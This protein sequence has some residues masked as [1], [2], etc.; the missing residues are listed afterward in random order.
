MVTAIQHMID[1]SPPHTTPPTCLTHPSPTEPHESH[2]E[3]LKLPIAPPS[4][5]SYNPPRESSPHDRT[6]YETED[7]D[8]PDTE[9]VTQ[10]R[11]AHIEAL[12]AELRAC[13]DEAQRFRVCIDER[14]RLTAILEAHNVEIAM[15]HKLMAEECLSYR[16]LCDTEQLDARYRGTWDHF[17]GVA[18][19]GG[20]ER[21]QHYG[22]YAESRTFCKQ[23]AAAAKEVP[24]WEEAVV[25]LNQIRLS[26]HRD[27]RKSPIK[28]GKAK[29]TTDDVS[30]LKEWRGRSSNFDPAKP[31][32]QTLDYRPVWHDEM[33]EHGLDIH[34]LVVEQGDGDVSP[35]PARPDVPHTRDAPEHSATTTGPSAAKR[36]L[37]YQIEDDTQD[38]RR[39]KQV[40]DQ[41]ADVSA[42]ERVTRQS[43][44]TV[45]SRS[46]PSSSDSDPS[47][48]VLRGHQEDGHAPP[49]R[50]NHPTPAPPERI[51]SPPVSDSQQPADAPVDC[52]IQRNSFLGQVHQHLDSICSSPRRPPSTWRDMTSSQMH[53]LLTHIRKPNT[54]TE[55]GPVEAYFVPSKE[56]RKLLDTGSVTVPIVVLDDQPF[57]WCGSSQPIEQLFSDGW[58]VD[59]DRKVSVQIPSLGIKKQSYQ[60]KSLRHI[61]DRFI[62]NEPT[63]D[64]WNLLNFANPLPPS[65][66]PRFLT[67]PNCQLI[68]RVREH[69]LSRNSAERETASAEDVGKWQAVTDW[70]L[71]SQGGHNTGPH[72]DSHGMGTWITVQGGGLGFGY[73]LPDR[74]FD[75]D[76]WRNDRSYHAGRNRYIILE[77]QQTVYFPPGTIHFVFRSPNVQTLA[78]GGHVLQWSGI[79]RWLHVIK[80]QELDPSTTNEHVDIDSSKFW[81]TPILELVRKRVQEGAVQLLGGA[82]VADDIMKIMNDWENWKPDVANFLGDRA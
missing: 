22:W 46:P 52:T 5:S 62:P 58:I 38:Q 13:T 26:R 71:M 54:D 27:I 41:R 14:D 3:T 42:P 73:I 39:K 2:L 7:I 82:D 45:P 35:L 29:I 9:L 75:W 64:P 50:S 61:R 57:E 6:P 76:A 33:P 24:E 16:H 53:H 8:L 43:P 67:G 11:A 20:T 81:R 19:K 51:N 68:Q 44:R 70:A 15:S 40:S 47:P 74:D 66:L 1:P 59:L 25:K 79:R 32:N 30:N 17:I 60:T 28:V 69:V 78:I 63:D 37:S 12:R 49:A 21:L 36:R 65:V 10:N 31:A 77:P 34:G 4:I 18:R 55:N 23:L 56:A 72:T 48:S 80:Q